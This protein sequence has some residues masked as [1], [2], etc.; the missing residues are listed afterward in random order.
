M[1]VGDFDFVGIATLPIEADPILIVDPNAVLSAPAT[2]QTLEPV[3]WR[4][5]HLSN[6]AHSVDLIQ[7]APGDRPDDSGASAPRFYV[8]NT[9]ADF[10]FVEGSTLSEQEWYNIVGRYD[11][12]TELAI[13]VNG[14]KAVNTTG[15]PATLFNSNAQFNVFA[16]DDGLATTRLAM[17]VSCCFLCVQ[18]LDDVA[19]LNQFQQTRALFGV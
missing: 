11:P 6:I 12:N 10:Y 19:I 4:N 5:R 9:G 13:F 7:L 2:A 15:I 16:Y 1:V 17:L 14:E 8:S 18:K 3:P